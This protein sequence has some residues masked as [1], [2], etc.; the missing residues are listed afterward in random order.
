MREDGLKTREIVENVKGE[1][2]QGSGEERV[3]GVSIDT[4]TLKRGDLFVAIKGEHYDAH[5]FLQKASHRGA[6]GA[7]ISQEVEVEVPEDFFLIKVS[8]TTKALG[9]LASSYRESFELPVVA[10]TGSAGK[11]TTKDMIA[12]ILSK[13]FVCRKNS[14]NLNNEFGLPLTLLSLEERDE[15]LI[16]EMGMRNLK[17]IQSLAEIASPQ[18]GV[19][20][21]VGP[22]HLETLGSIEN[23]AKGKE[24]LALAIPDDGHLILN[25]DDPYVSSMARESRARRLLF[26]I[27]GSQFDIQCSHRRD[28]GLDGIEF[29]IDGDDT[30]YHLQL[31]GT[32]NLYNALAAM[33]VAK[34]FQLSSEEIQ[35]GLKDFQPSPLRME[36]K[37]LVGGITLINDTY[38]ANPLSMERALETLSKIEGSR[39]VAILGDMLEL[40]EIGVQEH[41]HLGRRVF[42]MGIHLL[43]T[44]GTL[45]QQ[46]A[47]GALESGMDRER[48]YYCPEREGLFTSVQRIL[49]K[50]DVV[51]LKASRGVALEDLIYTLEER[52]P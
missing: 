3:S 19:I 36:I 1:L 8:D 25:G 40:G 52:V 34:V 32:H 22:T 47:E 13:R 16:T 49:T 41:H 44:T 14:G 5:M 48:V 42:E 51:L 21:N 24:E 26:G 20:T 27:H 6:V 18:I 39:R 17:E 31:P 45:G 7:L 15:V 30:L 29:S 10:I 50:G 37:K 28:L 9:D 23:V 12:S 38:N 35:E 2:Q 4:R 33:A 11:T 46:I 43:I